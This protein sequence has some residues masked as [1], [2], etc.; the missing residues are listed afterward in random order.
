MLC[1]NKKLFSK[2]LIILNSRCRSDILFSSWD[3]NR[4]YIIQLLGLSF[5]LRSRFGKDEKIV[6]WYIPPKLIYILIKQSYHTYN[7]NQQFL[8]LISHCVVEVFTASHSIDLPCQLILSPIPHSFMLYPSS[9]SLSRRDKLEFIS[10]AS[11]SLCAKF[12]VY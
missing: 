12:S 10:N 3:F 11:D 7:Q 9:C 6:K 5:R 1:S 8:I 4:K 2:L